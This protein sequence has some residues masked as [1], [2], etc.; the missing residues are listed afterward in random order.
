MNCTAAPRLE[1]HEPNRSSVFALE[2]TLA[3]AYC[4]KKLKSYIGEDTSAEEEEII[5]LHEQYYAH[6]MDE[7]TELYK[8][9]VLEKYNAAKMR[10]RD[11]A[12]LVEAQLDFSEF[13]PESFGTSDAIIVADGTLEVI[14]F[15]Y[16]KGVKVSA[17][18]NEQMMIYA[19]GALSKYSFEYCIKDVK[20]TIVQPRLGHISEFVMTADELMQWAKEELTPKAKEAFSGNGKQAPGG[21]C[22]FCRVRSK[23]AALADQSLGVM[24]DAQNPSL[25]SPDQLAKDV[26]PWL[27]TIKAWATSVEEYALQQA[28]IGVRYAGYKVVEGRSIR[29][30]SDEDAVKALLSK[31]GYNADEFM[32]PAQLCGISDLEKL[33]GKKRFSVLCSD[34]IVKPM[35]KPTLVAVDDK[36]EEYNSAAADF[37]EFIR[38]NS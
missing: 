29:K 34:Y 4:A 15:K 26:L 2:G 18:H 3:H 10:T 38:I 12:I 6:E 24:R 30:I 25:L 1:E 21:W 5:D 13:I 7:H 36:R 9:I 11:A 33:V 14:D 28:L 32:K 17:D 8:A 16:G 23:C 31:E 35:G 20:M 27:S 37:A 22:Q 19:L